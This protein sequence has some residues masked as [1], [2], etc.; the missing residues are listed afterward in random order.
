MVLFV[1]KLSIFACTR[2][3]GSTECEVESTVV[4]PDGES[5]PFEYKYYVCVDS[6]K[7]NC[8]EYLSHPRSSGK[9]NRYI[10][11]TDQLLLGK[12]GVYEKLLSDMTDYA[13]YIVSDLFCLY[14]VSTYHHYDDFIIPSPKSSVYTRLKNV[15][16]WGRKAESAS[17]DAMSA[18]LRKHSIE[19]HLEGMTDELVSFVTGVEGHGDQLSRIA[20]ACRQVNDH[21]VIA[22]VDKK[23]KT[24]PAAF[25][26]ADIQK[27]INCTKGHL[28]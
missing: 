17:A 28:Q 12:E 4:L 9:I 1:Y 25:G 11:S 21:W 26:K 22:N 13:L 19:L 5:F 2:L 23:K 15:F 18:E 24:E 20:L 3:P 27:V 10:E 8:Y 7:E 6:K 14:A 16:T